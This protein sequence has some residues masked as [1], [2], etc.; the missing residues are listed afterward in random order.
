MT[1]SAVSNVLPF[2]SALSIALY[3][4]LQH[5][6]KR[7]CVTWHLLVQETPSLFVGAARS[8]CP[9]QGH[10]VSPAALYVYDVNVLATQPL[11]RAHTMAV[12]GRGQTKVRTLQLWALELPAS[13]SALSISPRAATGSEY[14]AASSSPRSPRQPNGS[15]PT[16]SSARPQSSA[17]SAGHSGEHLNSPRRSEQR[18]ATPNSPARAYTIRAAR[19]DIVGLFSVPRS[20]SASGHTTPRALVHVTDSA[21]PHTPARP[22]SAA[23]SA[24]AARPGR[25]ATSA[26]RFMTLPGAM[27]Q[28]SPQVAPV[29][30]AAHVT[31]CYSAPS[32]PAW[33]AGRQGGSHPCSL[34]RAP[35]SARQHGLIVPPVSRLY[36]PLHS[37]S[38]R[39][40]EACMLGVQSAITATPTTPC[41]Y[42]TPSRREQPASHDNAQLQACDAYQATGHEPVLSGSIPQDQAA[43]AGAQP[44]Q[45]GPTAQKDT[46][47]SSSH[48]A[49][50]NHSCDVTDHSS[51]NSQPGHEKPVC[52]PVIYECNAS[53]CEDGC[54]L[55]VQSP[56]SA[57]EL[58]SSCQ[59]ALPQQPDQPEQPQ[60]LDA[61]TATQAVAEPLA[62]GCSAGPADTS[63]PAAADTQTPSEQ[64]AGSPP[65]LQQHAVS[66]AQPQP[67]AGTESEA[68]CSSLYSHS[69]D[70][71]DP[72]P[73]LNSH[74]PHSADPC[75]DCP[76]AQPCKQ[77][78]YS[79]LTVSVAKDERGLSH[80]SQGGVGGHMVAGGQGV[81]PWAKSPGEVTRRRDKEFC[82][83][84]GKVSFEYPHMQI[85]SSGQSVPI[86]CT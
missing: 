40:H 45:Q 68:S 21:A 66:A 49:S 42:S 19:P 53:Q 3:C 26:G 77:S 55:P 4:I 37:P 86:A 70:N 72:N 83:Y 82:A 75:F 27:E 58:T 44:E 5:A 20:S 8:S 56:A 64:D 76:S 43:A 80:A 6:C 17:Q 71:T 60:Q 38:P 36:T 2:A 51:Q 62:C 65:Q 13:L 15:P 11:Q 30:A 14:A 63:A 16:H 29:A 28:A 46:C 12:D 1:W 22:H 85:G 35:L 18:P 81:S 84:L 59:P 54:G 10:L 50:D 9:A 39:R 47:S 23:L 33:H 79:K 32:S 57:A 41:T 48:S 25:P 74:I 73:H 31:H 52:Q 67:A 7:I 24:R 61:A 34:V 69:T 78:G